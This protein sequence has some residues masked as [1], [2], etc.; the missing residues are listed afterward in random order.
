MSEPDKSSQQLPL[1]TININHITFAHQNIKKMIYGWSYLDKQVATMFMQQHRSYTT[2]NMVFSQCTS[3]FFT[4]ILQGPQKHHDTSSLFWATHTVQM[5]FMYKFV[6]NP[7]TNFAL[8]TLQLVVV[9]GDYMILQR[10]VY[11]ADLSH[12]NPLYHLKRMSAWENLQI[13]YF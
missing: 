2:Y 4:V 13:C 11:T 7:S 1:I 9:K 3:Q 5:Y 6:L 10:S 12:K 8:I